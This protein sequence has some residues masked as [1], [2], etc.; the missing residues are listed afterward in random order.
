MNSGESHS[1]ARGRGRPPL[2]SR[3]AV[4]ETAT[5][6][7]L[8]GLSMGKVASE[9]GVATQSLYRHVASRE[10][11]ISLTVNELVSTW[12]SVG[13]DGQTLD[14]WLHD[15]AM[16]AR[17]FLLRHPGLAEELQGLDAGTP[18]VVH[19]I[20]GDV[21]VLVERGLSPLTAFLLVRSVMNTTVSAVIRQHR[22]RSA[23]ASAGGAPTGFRRALD[24]VE[25]RSVPNLVGIESGV[26]QL[27]PDG[28]YDFIISTL[29]DGLVQ[30]IDSNN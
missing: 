29:I 28:Y 30:N 14:R 22:L 4:I 7:G 10:E 25:A 3:N 26:P 15:Y 19:Q 27:T 20:E 24:Q 9:L 21:A 12:N 8:D 17:E 23:R 11:L 16:N 13:D 6:L 1:V 2:I 5:G 18:N